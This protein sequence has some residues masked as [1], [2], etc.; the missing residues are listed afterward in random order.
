MSRSKDTV[1]ASYSLDGKLIKIYKTAVKAA[2]EFDLFH[3]TIDRA[4]RNDIMTVKNMIWRRYK[5]NEV[6][7][8]INP[9]KKESRNTISRPI[10]KLDEN[11]KIIETYKSIKYASKINKIDPHSLRDRLNNKYKCF[12]KTKFR[13]LTELEAKEFGY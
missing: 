6:P 1:I 4:T 3:R 10:A 2:E 9:I 12:G 5:I 7:T 13:Y 11:N 8:T